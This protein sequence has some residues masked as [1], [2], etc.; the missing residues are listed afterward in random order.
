MGSVKGLSRMDVSSI[1][2]AAASYLFAFFVISF[3]LGM[4]VGRW[5]WGSRTAGHPTGDTAHDELR[6]DEDFRAMGETVHPDGFSDVENEKNEKLS[7]LEHCLSE[8]RLL[9]SDAQSERADIAQKLAIV[10]HLIS[11]TNER[12]NSFLQDFQEAE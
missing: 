4:I 6:S 9:V 8:I 1:D 7:E 11:R 5:V 10:D 3:L 2:W 12:F